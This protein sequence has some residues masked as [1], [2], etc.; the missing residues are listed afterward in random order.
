MEK[1]TGD[2]YLCACSDN[3][4][5]NGANYIY[6]S[7]DETPQLGLFT[8]LYDTNYLVYNER[9]ITYYSP[10][11]LKISSLTLKLVFYTT[12]VNLCKIFN[13]YFS[14]NGTDWTEALA[15][16]NINTADLKDGAELTYDIDETKQ[17]PTDNPGWHYIKFNCIATKSDNSSYYTSYPHIKIN[18][19]E[20]VIPKYIENHIGVCS[21]DEY[22]RIDN[23]YGYCGAVAID[24]KTT[25]IRLPNYN[26]MFLQATNNLNN[27]TTIGAG[28]PNISGVVSQAEWYGGFNNGT[29][30]F[31]ST[32]YKSVDTND[33]H[34]DGNGYSTITFDASC[35]S[36]VYG[37]SD[38]VQPP[39][40]T[41]NY[42]I[43][44]YNELINAKTEDAER[45]LT[46]FK[47]DAKVELD[48][49]TEDITE[50][51]NK[52]KTDIDTVVKN[53]N[54]I[55][56]SFFDLCNPDY[57]A[58]VSL[59]LIELQ[60]TELSYEPEYYDNGNYYN[61]GYIIKYT[62]EADGFIIGTID[63][64]DHYRKLYINDNLISRINVWENFIYLPVHKG[65]EF[66][67]S[68]GYLISWDPATYLPKNKLTF[69]P[70]K[71]VT[72]S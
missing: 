18:A 17:T 63:S 35:S 5:T 2:K 62:V 68:L 47:N 34:T 36:Y 3:Q 44:V 28:L 61:L 59:N 25:N 15:E 22:N 69:F 33:D 11:P 41:I 26:N 67:Y 31:I 48:K 20:Y 23:K 40:I 70:A 42:Y 60:S 21:F 72:L 16:I 66:K 50:T 30:A 49:F 9:S 10:D 8:S 64:D 13:V 37:N 45:I 52:F 19:K 38:T 39:A 7:F 58:G 27:G 57:S 51:Y 56:A 32:G 24:T 4:L 65:D 12:D 1:L 53:F 46:S 6:Y 71:R 43:Q 14:T 54:N 29:G 55:Q